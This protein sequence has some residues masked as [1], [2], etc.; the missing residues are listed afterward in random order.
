MKRRI[1]AGVTMAKVRRTPRVQTDAE[2]IRF[3]SAADDLPE[4][5]WRS[6]SDPRD[7]VFNER[8]FQLTGMLGAIV[9]GWRT[10]IHPDDRERC[11]HAH[12]RAP[13]SWRPFDWLSR[14]ER[15]GRLMLGAQTHAA[16]TAQQA[17]PISASAR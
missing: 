7:C 6:A 2:V 16:V 3:L 14:E 4:I 9:T 12:E 8:R 17:K 5:V 13:H 10:M 1:A 15:Q 11:D